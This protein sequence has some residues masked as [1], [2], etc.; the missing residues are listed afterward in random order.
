MHQGKMALQQNHCLWVVGIGL[1][2]QRAEAH[3]PYHHIA[4]PVWP[5]QSPGGHEIDTVHRQKHQQHQG[6]R[7]RGG[8]GGDRPKG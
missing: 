5:S 7:L 6:V 1:T 2:G 8:R 3:R 4:C